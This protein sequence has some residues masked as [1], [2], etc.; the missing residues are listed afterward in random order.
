MTGYMDMS[1]PAVQ[2]TLEED[3]QEA[4]ARIRAA[5]PTPNEVTGGQIVTTHDC[6]AHPILVNREN[7]DN[8]LC[9]VCDSLLALPHQIDPE[10]FVSVPS[11]FGW[12]E[13][14]QPYPRRSS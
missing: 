9:N 4:L 14:P 11:P 3:K 13:F 6:F 8:L 2:A 12:L 10:P 7:G 5:V 1:D